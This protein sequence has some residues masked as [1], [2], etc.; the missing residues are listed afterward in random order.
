MDEKAVWRGSSSQLVNLGSFLLCGLLAAAV[1]TAAVLLRRTLAPL[2]FYGVLLV[3]AI[4]LI[5]LFPALLRWLR[6]R[7]QVYEVTS[8]RLKLTS[9]IFSRRTQIMELYRVK[10][11]SMHEPFWMRLFKLGTITVIT[12]DPTNPQIQLQAIP[13]A[14]A[15]LDELRRHVEVCRDA[16]RVRQVDF[17]EMNEAPV[18][19]S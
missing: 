12:A 3:A 8:Q 13:R 1:I 6:V 9:G 17:D 19:D 5:V 7:F 2:G 11:Y 10:D 18:H 16:K 14:A 4:V 15:L